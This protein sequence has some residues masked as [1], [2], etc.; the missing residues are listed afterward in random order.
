MKLKVSI[1][2]KLIKSI[3]DEVYKL[4]Y[5]HKIFFHVILLFPWQLP[6]ETLVMYLLGVNTT[7][8]FGRFVRLQPKLVGVLSKKKFGGG[9]S[10]LLSDSIGEL[11]FPTDRRIERPK[12][13]STDNSN[14]SSIIRSDRKTLVFDRSTDWTS[15]IPSI[16]ARKCFSWYVNFTYSFGSKFVGLKIREA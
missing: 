12:I 5:P 13:N 7:V 15:N 6:E 8:D 11:R 14:Q 2:Y 9:Q 10:F 4:R 3:N 16:Y 1:W